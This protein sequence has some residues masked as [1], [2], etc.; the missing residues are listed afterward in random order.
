MRLE[1]ARAIVTGA[2][3]GLGHHFTVQLVSSG[4][5]VI[6]GDI[7]EDG[8]EQLKT[9]CRELPGAVAHGQARCGSG[10]FGRRLCR[11]GL[12]V[13]LTGS[14]LMAREVIAAMLKRQ[15]KDGIIV[16]TSPI[17][18][19]GQSGAIELCCLKSRA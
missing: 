4:A 18:P 14:Y 10:S 1:P 7:N 16:K 17:Q 3:S 15:I 5:Q 9:V 6:G 19:C 2:A 12:D 8:L 11:R 13:N